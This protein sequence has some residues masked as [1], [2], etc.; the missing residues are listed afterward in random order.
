VACRNLLMYYV[1]QVS[2]QEEYLKTKVASFP[3]GP[4][5]ARNLHAILSMADA[6]HTISPSAKDTRKHFLLD[7]LA[8]ISLMHKYGMRG[9][10]FRRAIFFRAATVLVLDQ[11]EGA[12]PAARAGKAL[13]D[14]EVILRGDDG[15]V[16]S[17]KSMCMALAS[18]LGGAKGADV[19]EAFLMGRGQYKPIPPLEV[20][21]RRKKSP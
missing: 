14:L 5:A 1:A 13:R 8:T 4:R 17:N 6:Y 9:R 21:R 18:L 10:D 7:A 3:A 12:A 16:G 19:A 20:R 11:T 2:M 15:P